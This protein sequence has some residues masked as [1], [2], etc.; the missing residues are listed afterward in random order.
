MLPI[1][2]LVYGVCAMPA[3]EIFAPLGCSV[4]RNGLGYLGYVL[5][6]QQCLVRVVVGYAQEIAGPRRRWK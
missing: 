2:M 1:N 3:D 6:Y 5:L 4:R